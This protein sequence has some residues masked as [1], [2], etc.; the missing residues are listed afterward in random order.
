MCSDTSINGPQATGG[1]NELRGRVRAAVHQ[2][3]L[4]LS[5]LTTTKGQGGTVHPEWTDFARCSS[6]VAV[7]HPG[8]EIV[9]RPAVLAARFLG[10]AHTRRATGLF[11]RVQAPRKGQRGTGRCAARWWHEHLHGDGSGGAG[12]EGGI[13]AAAE[14]WARAEPARL[15]SNVPGPRQPPLSSSASRPG[16]WRPSPR[17]GSL[18]AEG[19]TARGVDCG[20]MRVP[21]DLHSEAPRRGRY[22]T[23]HGG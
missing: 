19:L 17:R 21:L 18:L 23:V 20:H 16:F 1:R 9:G 4:R 2:D 12:G 15:P 3:R 13:G 6:A 11:R 7:V 14:T 5:T 8:L 10:H 22:G